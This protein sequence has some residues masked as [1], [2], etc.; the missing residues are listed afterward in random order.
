L[1]FDLDHGAKTAILECNSKA[2]GFHIVQGTD[3]IGSWF[4]LARVAEDG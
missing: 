2:G 1:P 4:G 3:C